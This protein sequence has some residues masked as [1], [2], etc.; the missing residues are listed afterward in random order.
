MT[1]C[2]LTL[3]IEFL[4]ASMAF[5]TTAHFSSHLISLWFYG[6]CR[7]GMWGFRSAP[8]CQIDSLQAAAK[9]KPNKSENLQ[10]PSHSSLIELFLTEAN[11]NGESNCCRLIPLVY[12]A[13][14]NDPI[15]QLSL[16]NN[17]TWLRLNDSQLARAWRDSYFLMSVVYKLF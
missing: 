6:L 7:P 10:L 9:E 15:W 3:L 4:P 14:S 13:P 1:R 16:Y 2:V 12:L 5:T 17:L 8:S 11:W